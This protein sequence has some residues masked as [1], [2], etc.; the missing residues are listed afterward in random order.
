MRWRDLT[1]RESGK[2]KRM[3]RR[4][5]IKLR[6]KLEIVSFKAIRKFNLLIKSCI[7]KIYMGSVLFISSL[8]Q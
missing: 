8:N 4:R 7:W 1:R 3:A 2:G 6:G 5:E